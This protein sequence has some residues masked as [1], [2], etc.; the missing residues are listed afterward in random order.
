MTVEA[1]LDKLEVR[2][3]EVQKDKQKTFDELH[4][5]IIE[6]KIMAQN[7]S[8]KVNKIYKVMFEGNGKPSYES[9][10]SGCEGSFKTTLALLV[11]LY[12]ATIVGMIKLFS[13]N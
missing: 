8:M 6:L 9:R 10:L 1:R 13:T 2:C 12:T 7:T 4:A 11:P 3:G 5:D